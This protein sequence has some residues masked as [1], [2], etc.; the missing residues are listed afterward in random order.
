[1]K[2]HTIL[3]TGLIAVILG[4]LLLGSTACKMSQ[5]RYAGNIPPEK[6]T[7][8][9][10]DLAY[11]YRLI[12]IG[13]PFPDTALNVPPTAR[14]RSYLGLPSDG[15]FSISDI[16]AD[17]VLVEMLNVHCEDCLNRAA[18]Y[19]TLFQK[20]AADSA[21]KDRVKMIAVG[22]GNTAAEI[23]RFSSEY[24][25]RFPLVAD[26]RFDLHAATGKP[27]TPFSIMVR[28][29]K[30]PD[31]AVVALTA[32]GIDEDFAGLY[33]DMT[34]LMTLDIDV[35]RE[36]RSQA[37]ADR[38]TVA[39]PQSEPEI[40]V[41]IRDAM[42]R[43]AGAADADMEFAKLAIDGRHV[44]AG[45]VKGSDGAKRLFAEVISRPTICEVCQDVHFFYIF[46]EKGAVVEFAPLQVTKWGN[47]EW[48]EADVEVMRQR[49]K[50]RFIFTPFYFNPQLDAVSSATITSAIIFDGLSDGKEI[51]DFLKQEGLI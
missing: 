4:G 33:Q 1:M 13:E 14:D 45:T 16:S 48:T 30:K 7:L 12:Q 27:V 41:R 25:V 31:M 11:G 8:A 36:R 17:L 44:Y 20:I 2:K 15:M 18:F 50:G 43:I 3:F 40:S 22:V 35:L 49:L 37:R 29:Q 10:E 9:G 5:W 42:M 47:R 51:F 38:M 28:L 24:N 19:N 46:N 21:T 26:P 32:P 34:A 23:Q 6:P 39:P